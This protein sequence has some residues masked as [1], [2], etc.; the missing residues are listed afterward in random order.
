[1]SIKTST[2]YPPPVR[3]STLS[4]PEQRYLFTLQQRAPLN[5]VDATL[6][7]VVIAL[8]NAGLDNSQ[9]GQSNQNQEII[10]VKAD[11]SGN[12]VTITGGF[13]GSQV[14]TAQ[15][16]NAGSCVRFKSDAVNW[17]LVGKL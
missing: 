10:Y 3:D 9:T 1:M 6:G 16:P 2:L 14:L 5:V 13:G 12:T 4:K 17:L 8:P 15:S 11:A 7:P